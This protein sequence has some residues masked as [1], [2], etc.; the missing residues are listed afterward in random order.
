[1]R[2]YKTNEKIEVKID[3][4]S[5]FISP[6]SY[7]QKIALHPSFM[8]AATGDLEKGMEAV[9]ITLKMSVKDIKGLYDDKG[10]WKLTLVD[11]QMSDEDANDLLNLPISNKLQAVVTALIAGVPTVIMDGKVPMEGV[12]I[13]QSKGNKKQG[14]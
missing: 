11:G 10:E 13:V 9:L 7:Q 3:D 5:V 14:K 1:M 12:S 2:I 8:A 4:I 6:L